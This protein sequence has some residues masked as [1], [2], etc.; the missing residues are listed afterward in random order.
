MNKTTLEDRLDELKVSVGNL[1][2]MTDADFTAL[3]KKVKEL[4]EDFSYAREEAKRSIRY[5]VCLT[6]PD[7][8]ELHS[9]DVYPSKEEAD[10]ALEKAVESDDLVR[11]MSYFFNFD[12]GALPVDEEEM[13]DSW[14]RDTYV[15]ET[16]C[17]DRIDIRRDET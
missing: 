6:L 11:E 3:L 12:F 8:R 15:W 5:R 7:E 2:D 9:Y 16:Y 1:A 17:V 10:F 14:D 4:P 13:K